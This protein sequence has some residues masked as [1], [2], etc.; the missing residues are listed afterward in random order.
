MP[1]RRQFLASAAA[2]A[3][4]GLRP[5]LAKADVPVSG[6][7]DAALKPFDDLLTKFLADN[8]V[9][10]AA[11]TIT[12]NGKLVYA[13]GFGYVDVERKVAVAPNASSQTIIDSSRPR[14][15]SPRQASSDP[16]PAKKSVKPQPAAAIKP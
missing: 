4:G 12:K 9:P 11:V 14:P 15:S 13:R 10:G 7:A 8:A 3:S 16:A 2:L 6:A 1:T 5:P